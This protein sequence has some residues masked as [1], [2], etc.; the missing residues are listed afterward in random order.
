[1]SYPIPL[2]IWALVDHESWVKLNPIVDPHLGLVLILYRRYISL[3]VE[4][5]HG[6]MW[7]VTV[8]EASCMGVEGDT[9][10]GAP[11]MDVL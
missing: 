9:S 2:P 3:R 1:M 4:G 11:C 10:H 7:R 6:A 5:S 8:E